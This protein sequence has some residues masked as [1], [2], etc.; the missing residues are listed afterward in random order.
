MG[1]NDLPRTSPWPARLLG[2]DPWR[3]PARTTKELSREFGVD[4]WGSLLQKARECTRELTVSEVDSW[5]LGDAPTTCAAVGAKLVPMA[6]L[7]AH[8]Q[9]LRIIQRTLKPYCPA[10]ALV[11]LG[12]GYG[13]IIL[14]LASRFGFRELPIAAGELTKSGL[15]LL[16]RLAKDMG[17]SVLSGQCDL[18]AKPITK[19]SIPND[20]IIFTSYA[21]H[22]VPTISRRFV[23]D[24]I[25][26]RPR[27]VVHFE[28]CY[29]HCGSDTLLGLMRRRYIEINGY[30]TNLATILRDEQRCG[31]I[32]ILRED[33]AVMGANPL[34]P[35]SV[36]AWSPVSGATS[37]NEHRKG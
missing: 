30:N 9:H 13:S 1:L 15:L 7:D 6:A 16:D 3:P 32:R 14:A 4:K 17:L 19:L 29:E 22:Y 5:R 34:L 23:N 36:I 27:V 11:E 26:L 33:P 35:A 21:L 12:A 24:I 25:G 2:L 37:R 10:G 28:P 8:R 18:T 20:A 31:R